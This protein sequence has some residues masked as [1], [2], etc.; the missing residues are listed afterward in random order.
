MKNKNVINLV[1]NGRYKN[2]FFWLKFIYLKY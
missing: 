2:A 1:E